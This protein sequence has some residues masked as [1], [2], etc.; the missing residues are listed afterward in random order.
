MRKASGRR[1]SAS[2]VVAVVA[3]VVA[4]SGTAVAAGG[5]LNGSQIKK[6]SIP[7]NR[8]ANNTIT[9]KQI[10]KSKLGVVP[11]AKD[12]N[13]A[14]TA[15]SAT[16]ATNATN[17]A[18][19][20]TAGSAASAPIAKVTYT[21]NSGSL[22]TNY[23]LITATCPAGTNVIGGGAQVSNESNDYVNDSYPDGNSGWSVD[24]YGPSTDTGTVTAIC[25]PAASAGP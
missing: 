13:Y 17:A 18:N 25:A 1:P 19:A 4:M 12:A 20:T 11:S 9:A 10:N 6:N 21:T 5:L 7:G 3:L 14:T 24:I 16:N 15:G 23:A 22:S 2:I 8:L